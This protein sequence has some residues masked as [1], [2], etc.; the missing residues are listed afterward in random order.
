MDSG[1]SQLTVGVSFNYTGLQSTGLS[2]LTVLH[3][4][5]LVILQW[6]GSLTLTGF[7]TSE[8]MTVL[9][10]KGEQGGGGGLH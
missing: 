6:T 1:R 2:I 10:L 5:A 4:T 8:Q 7:K 9:D 3:W